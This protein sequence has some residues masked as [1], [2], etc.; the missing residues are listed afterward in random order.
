MNDI[1]AKKWIIEI[2][3]RMY[4]KDYV[5]SND[6][7]ITVM[8]DEGYIW[9]TP[10]GVSK[11]HMNEEMLL[12]MDIDGNI[13]EG[14]YKPTSEIK[15]HLRV[16]KEN[17]EVRSVT[18]AHPPFSTAFA[19]C[20]K[21][22]DKPYLI[23]AVIGLGTIPVAPYALPGTQEV[24]DSIAPFCK[25]YNGC[26]LANHGLLTWG[27]TPEQAFFRMES[28]E[29]VAK[30][31]SIVPSIGKAQGFNKEEVERLLERRKAMGISTGGLPDLS[32]D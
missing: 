7:N 18:H 26:L 9:A 23:E 8:T 22:I 13:I 30:T 17:P 20:H 32:E 5:S 2:G 6:G 27:N 31:Y 14:T 28:A 4:E 10:T 29:M 16:F 19:I 25:D 24:P 12:K 3:K 21:P 11:G 1:E 15:M